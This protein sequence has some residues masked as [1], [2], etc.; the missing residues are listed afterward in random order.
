MKIFFIIIIA[1]ML[2]RNTYAEEIDIY[3]IVDECAIEDI[4][5][6][7]D[8]DFKSLFQKIIDGD[9]GIQDIKTG[10]ADVFLKEIKDT[11]TIFRGIIFICILNGIIN[12][13][14]PSNIAGTAFT[15]THVLI[16]ALCMSSLKIA[17]GLLNDTVESAI[18]IMESAMPVTLSLLVVNGY[19]GG[20]GMTGVFMYGFIDFLS[21]AVKF[22]ILPFISFYT[23]CTIVNSISPK[24]ML[25]RL[26]ELFYKGCIWFVRILA[27]VFSGAVAVLKMYM[28]DIDGITGKVLGEG[29]KAVPVVGD[30]F[31]GSV[32]SIMK[33][34]GAIRGGFGI[35][36]IISILLMAVLPLAKMVV[37]IIIYKLTAALAEPISDKGIVEIID[38][39]GNT[40]ILVLAVM[41]T[42]IAMFVTG[43]FILLSGFLGG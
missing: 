23:V 22:V 8:R 20:A 41:F 10:I 25:T 39:V 3:S 42:V 16:V 14:A 15:I 5:I 32:G 2:C 7:T 30:I 11:S 12:T 28:S 40:G 33:I 21:N 34:A 1:L 36:L 18:H 31:S 26:S 27:F 17:E 19:S 37:L 35:A 38:S 9:F 43:I 6:A 29:V 13:A 24:D 4:S